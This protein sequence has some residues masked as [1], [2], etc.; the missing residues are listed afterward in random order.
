MTWQVQYWVASLSSVLTAHHM[1]LLLIGPLVCPSKTIDSASPPNHHSP[2]RQELGDWYLAVQPVILL[3]PLPLG[4]YA[5]TESARWSPWLP[6]LQQLCGRQG[7]F[8]AWVLGL[9]ALRS[10]WS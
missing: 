9:A 1:T 6:Q 4:T 3:Q 7:G 10:R 8:P 5:A 2:H